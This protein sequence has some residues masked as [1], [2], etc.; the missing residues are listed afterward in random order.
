M[1]LINPLI[2]LRI[3]SSIMLIETISFMICLPVGVIYKESLLPFILSSAITGILFII[4]RIVTRKADTT[5]ISNRDSYLAVTLSW[6]VFSLIG[7][8]PYLISSTIPSFIDALFES[9]SG[10]TTTGA[11]IV[12]DIESLPYSI[13]FWRSFTHWIGGLGIIVLVI[14]ILPSLRIP[15]QQL[16]VLESSLKEKIHPKTKA[17]GFRLLFIYLGL[18][19]SEVVF[20]YLGEMN[21]FESICHTFGTVATGGFS[22][23]NAS[24]A[25]YSAYTQYV[26]TVFM[27]LSGISYVAYYYIIKLQFSKVKNNEELWFYLGTITI[28]VV[29]VVVILLSKSNAPYE[30]VFREGL[31]QVISIITTTGYVT[32]DYLLWP[33]A[34]VILLF[35]LLFAG[36]NTGSS[37][38]SIKMARHLIV[39]KNIRN[40][41]KKLIHQNVITQI[42]L[43]GLSLSEK[44]N[45]SIISFV[46]IYLFIFLSGTIIIILT[47]LDPITSASGVAATLGNVGPAL[48]TLGPVC[49]YSHIPG[50]SKLVF[51]VLMIV[52]R[53]EIITVFVLFTRSFWRL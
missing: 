52:G 11:S 40:V 38:S 41:F 17:I 31:F 1:K 42:K 4:L 48:G 10:F 33:P 29:I 24:I 35:I 12:T 53:L 49:N 13:L 46:M 6:L 36:A 22:T 43:N 26:I 30:P 18:T 47:G 3:L 51:I 32:A 20:L 37:T 9:A 50:I 5:K 25:E 39:L 7:T 2:I 15:A 34:G 19:V 14:I 44:V 8:L 16:L 27:L 45:T 23:R 21:L 28:S